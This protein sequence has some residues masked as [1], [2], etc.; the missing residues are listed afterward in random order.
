ML[1]GQRHGPDQGMA[2]F[3]T[4]ILQAVDFHSDLN[5]NA[6]LYKRKICLEK[7]LDLRD[8]LCRQFLC[9]PLFRDASLIEKF[10]LR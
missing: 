7:F 6:V 3:G 5:H 2:G 4:D 9:I 8:F 1:A 10:E